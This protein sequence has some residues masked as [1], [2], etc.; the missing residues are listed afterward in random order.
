M[1]SGKPDGI[2]FKV[3]PNNSMF[4]GYFDG[5]Q[6]HGMG[7]GI[8]SRGEVYQAVER[9]ALAL[10]RVVE[11]GAVLQGGAAGRTADDQITIADLTGVAVQDL[12]IASAVWAGSG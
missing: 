4:E 8:T 2:G 12:A 7:R 6:I 10:D 11:L 5:G 1:D 3:Y 9:G